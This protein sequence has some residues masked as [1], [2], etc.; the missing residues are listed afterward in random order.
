MRH[1]SFPQALLTKRGDVADRH[2]L[3]QEFSLTAT[4]VP[5]KN[6]I[7]ST[8]IVRMAALSRIVASAIWRADRA[9]SRFA[10]PIDRERA[11]SRS[12]VRLKI[13]VATLARQRV[14]GVLCIV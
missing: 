1:L 8:A 9:I 7:V 10:W 3:F 11:W 12:T 14:V 4:A 13:Y 6:S 2:C 5:G